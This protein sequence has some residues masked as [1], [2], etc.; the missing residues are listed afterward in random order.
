MTI[1]SKH[2]VLILHMLANY[3]ETFGNWTESESLE[4]STWRELEC[5]NRVIYTFSNELESK[6]V[7]LN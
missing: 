2:L 1:Q 4:S 7:K 5:V 3:I 6:Q